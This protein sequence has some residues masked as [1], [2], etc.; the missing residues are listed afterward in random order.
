MLEHKEDLKWINKVMKEIDVNLLSLE[1]NDSE[2]SERLLKKVKN[3]I[4]KRYKL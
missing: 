1:T 4:N 3:T 2:S